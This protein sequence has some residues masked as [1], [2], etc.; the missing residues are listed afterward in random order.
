MSGP[1]RPVR[2]S[3]R[4][5]LGHSACAGFALGV[6]VASRRA[7]AR[8]ASKT[9]AFVPNAWLSVG[10]DD[11][12]TVMLGKSEMGQGV[13]TALPMLVAEELRADWRRI[14][15]E[16]APA[17]KA[18][19]MKGDFG[20]QV[21]GGS[22]SVKSSWEP[23]REAGA[24]ARE[25]LIA[26]AARRWKVDPESCRAEDGVIHGPGDRSATFGELAAAATRVPVPRRPR[27]FA[28]SSYVLVGRSIDR[29]DVPS[30]VDGSA[31]FGIDVTRP[32]LRVA[33]IARPPAAGATIAR[34]D[35]KA[36]LAVPGVRAV[37]P[38]GDGIAVVAD[39]TWAARKGREALAVAWNAGPN[40]ALDDAE[41]R[42]R[43]ETAS[44]GRAKVVRR[45]GDPDAAFERATKSIEAVYETPL[46]AH[47]TMEPQNC[48]ADAREGFCEVW[49]PVQN[50]TLALET[51]AK[52]ARLP[53]SAVRIHTTLLGGGFGRR[54]E[55]DFVAEAVQISRV[56]REPVK[57][58]WTREDDM[59]HDVYR[60][61]SLNVMRA[62]LD[63]AGLPLVWTHV[64]S[65]PSILRRIA[66]YASKVITDPFATDGARQLPYDVPNVRVAWAR[67][68]LP[69][70]FGFWRSVGY[71]NNSYVVECFLDEVAAAGGF[72]PLELRRRLLSSK[73]RLR[74][75]LELAAAKAGWGTPL[76]A[77]R[78]RGIAIADSF[79]S[80]V[81]QVA[82]VSV[83]GGEIRVHRVV[84]A[85]DAGAIVHPGIVDAQMQSGVVFGL[86]AAMRGRIS[87]AGG[88]VATSNFHDYPLLRMKECPVIDVHR[89]PSDEEHGGIGEP[90]VPPI[91]PA[92]AN[93]VF[94][95]TG[96]PVRRLPIVP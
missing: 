44:K 18:Y 16:P 40:A 62:G 74:A 36:A 88:A 4:A 1:A 84:V 23:L 8:A 39:G 38:V 92:V 10:E 15:V 21:T 61:P 82:E 86:T 41:I 26:A 51:A 76:P 94:A 35:E 59:Q 75:V 93:A 28:P 9:K 81:A 77:G 96:R 6:A 55:A 63:A 54:L 69:L 27:R 66:P 60:P 45:E 70:P 33:M 17:A 78:A 31:R 22:T 13:M 83:D 14:R 49:G 12:V 19:V 2:L 89:V 79:G 30:K 34:H 11:A 29:L 47:A 80:V 85:Y 43:L 37:V 72:D 57:V 42:R 87:V 32:G 53:K 52:H 95:A 50:Q 24:A 58:V 56:I 48:T 20:Y 67:A 71:S 73:P 46:L 25:M 7:P 68:D 3:R 90:G 5:F 65:S 91:A 64:V